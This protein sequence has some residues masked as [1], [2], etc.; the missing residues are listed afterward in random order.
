MSYVEKFEKKK[1]LNILYLII[2]IMTMRY[3][4]NIVVVSF[5]IFVN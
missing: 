4:L 5:L 1:R 3:D 2:I